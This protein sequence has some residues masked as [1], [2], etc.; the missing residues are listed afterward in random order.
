MARTLLKMIVDDSQL[1]QRSV[2]T[3]M[4]FPGTPQ[5]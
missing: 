5:S 2:Q 1:E 4:T 3:V